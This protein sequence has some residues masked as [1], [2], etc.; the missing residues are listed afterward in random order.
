MKIA[1]VGS[2]AAGLSAAL[3]LSERHEVLL[4]EKDDRFGGHANTAVVDTKDGLVPVDTRYGADVTYTLAVPVEH[5]EQ[6]AVELKDRTAGRVRAR[7]EGQP[8]GG[9]QA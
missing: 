9:D 3:A 6:V 2:G 5:V 8:I 7:C 1:V 4:F